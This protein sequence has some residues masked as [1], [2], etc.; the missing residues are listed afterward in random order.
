MTFKPAYTQEFKQFI[1]QNPGLIRKFARAYKEDAERLVDGGI[2]IAKY[3]A[4]IDIGPG[5]NATPN[6]QIHYKLW[7]VDVGE[8]K[9]FV[10]ETLRNMDTERNYS[11]GLRQFKLTHR[12]S[13]FARALSKI[14]KHNIKVLEPHLGATYWDTSFIV[15]DYCPHPRASRVSLPGGLKRQL[16][17]FGHLSNLIAGIRDVHDG[18]AF[19][20]AKSGKLILNDPLKYHD[21]FP[22][23]AVRYAGKTLRFAFRVARGKKTGLDVSEGYESAAGLEK[24]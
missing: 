4:G 10:K 22:I 23:R 16:W 8:R 13:R 7:T 17:A 14:W 20:D 1:R 19:Y 6:G 2:I 24:A 18:N 3:K 15:M 9:F 11:T 21:V 5:G 12:L